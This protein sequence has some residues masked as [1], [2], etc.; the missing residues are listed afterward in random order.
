MCQACDARFLQVLRA[1]Q[2]AGGRRD[3]LRGLGALA[4]ASALGVSPLHAATARPPGQ[5]ASARSADQI[6]ISRTMHTLD[7]RNTVVQALAV[8]QGRIVARGSRQDILGLAG[9]STQVIDLGDQ[10]VLPGF[11]EPHMHSNFCSLRP[12]LDVGP[13][14]TDTLAQALQKIGAAAQRA[15]ARG[16]VQ[17]KMLDPSIMPGAALDRH[18]LDAVS[19]TVPVFVLEANG[20]V[21]CVNSAAIQVAGLTR[22]VADPPQARFG[23][24]AQGELSGRLEEPNA[25]QPFIAKMPTPSPQ[26]LVALLR[27]DL[28]DAS[29]KG[30][31]TLHDAGIGAL[32]G[33]GD[34][35]LIDAVMAGNPGVRYARFLVSTHFKTWQRMGLRP[36]PRSRRFTLNGIKAWADGSNQGLTGYQRNP[37]LGQQ[38]RGAL[39][40]SPAEIEAVIRQA[41]QSG[42]QIG[43]HA[44]G[45]AAIDTVL[46]AFERVCGAGG[47]R[48][49]R[50][51]IE[52]CSILDAG[53]IARM[54]RLGVSPSF[55]I[56]HVHYWG[57]ALRDRLLGPHR[58]NRLDPCRSALAGG[59]RVSLHSDYNVTHIDPLRC[60]ENAVTRRL[61]EDG[62]VL[63]PDER[64]TPL[65]ALRTMTIDAAWQ[66]H[67][68]R[69]CG[70]L[71]VGKAADLVV[72]AQ[73]PL[74]VDPDRIG[75]IAVRST[76]L[77]GERRYAA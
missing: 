4:A 54:A 67:L 52:H 1:Y 15:P 12:W 65:Q 60:I 50:H 25:F 17:A 49:L 28:D 64:I 19:P 43:V 53:Q 62:S 26:D 56:G 73:D 75:Q 55:L 51:R 27:A 72:L 35:A 9:R 70:S 30:C 6:F 29:A 20:H 3:V 69:V 11:V 47:A 8:R 58:A 33:E 34:L 38:T 45:D 7:R 31:T 22:D 59:L 68:D 16:W 2:G 74:T 46:D 44:N 24:D 36:G 39:N 66:C 14:T 32:F 5:A 41:H 76:W 40:Y 13:F 23:R 57:V 37:Y 18:A 77:D 48:A 61:R 21:A 42:W 71:E 10:V 63:N